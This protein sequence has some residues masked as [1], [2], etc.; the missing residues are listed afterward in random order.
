[1]ESVG[2]QFAHFDKTRIRELQSILAS[3]ERLIDWIERYHFPPVD[4]LSVG[5]SGHYRQMD[6]FLA[7]VGACRK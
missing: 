5:A 2:L 7:E 1:M 6:D 3:R 4:V